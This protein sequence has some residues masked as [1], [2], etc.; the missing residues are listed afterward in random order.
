MAHIRD[1]NLSAWLSNSTSFLPNS[2][3]DAAQPPPHGESAHHHAGTGNSRRNSGSYQARRNSERS[4]RFHSGRG[5]WHTGG[6]AR[7]SRELCSSTSR[8]A[9]FGRYAGARRD[10]SLF[11]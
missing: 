9:G 11:G 7:S 2:R 4:G 10:A 1:T 3:H 8:Q 5:S 6:H